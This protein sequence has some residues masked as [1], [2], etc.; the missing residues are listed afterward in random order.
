MIGR[1][2]KNFT[3]RQDGT[4]RSY[5][6]GTSHFDRQVSRDDYVDVR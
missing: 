3:A 1:F 2:G 4:W 6:P 5:F